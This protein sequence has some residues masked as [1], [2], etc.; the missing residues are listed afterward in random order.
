MDRI[1]GSVHYHIRWAQI[2]LLDWESFKTRIE[3]DAAAQ[4]LAPKRE[5][6]YRG[7][8]RRLPAMPGCHKSE[9]T[10]RTATRTLTRVARRLLRR[11]CVL[12]SPAAATNTRAI[13]WA[14]VPARRALFSLP[15][16]VAGQL[17]SRLLISEIIFA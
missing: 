13:R 8:W 12:C 9:N 15:V 7:S 17:D 5:I 1:D 6:H 3:A 4:L 14:I 10:A 16:H 11:R 2:P